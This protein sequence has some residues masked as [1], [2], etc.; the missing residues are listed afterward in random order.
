[1]IECVNGNAGFYKNEKSLIKREN[2]EPEESV[3]W[4][5]IPFVFNIGVTN[6][7]SWSQTKYSAKIRV[8]NTLVPF[9]LDSRN[10]FRLFFLNFIGKV[11]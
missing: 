4:H 8:V 2:A 6:S 1:M 10:L 7:S 3:Q 5:K 9:N 11:R